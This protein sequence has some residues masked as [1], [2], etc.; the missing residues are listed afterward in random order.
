[1]RDQAFGPVQL[2]E[3]FWIRTDVRQALT[4][5][6]IGALIRLLTQHGIGQTR[7]ATATGLSQARVSELARDH[8]KVKALETFTRIADGL[9]MPDH[10][11]IAL[12]VAPHQPAPV[13]D[14]A[15]GHDD[16]ETEL[17]RQIASARN[18][19]TTVVAAL[20]QETDTIRLL[21]RRLGAP[22][23]T[24]K[25]SAHIDL[26][27]NSLRHSLRPG[28]REPLAAVLA[29]AEA[30]AGWQCIDMGRLHTAWGHFENAIAAARGATGTS[31]LAFSSGEQAY[32]LLDLGHPAEALDMVRAAWDDT[33]RHIPGQL[34]GWLR[35]AEA[36][37]AAVLRREDDCRRAL[38]LAAAEITDGPPDAELPYLALN[39][40]HLARWRGN[41]LIHFG[42]PGT[43]TELSAALAQMNGFTRAE[44]GLRVDLAA[45][46]HATGER[47]EARGH[48]ARA[49]ELARITGSARQCSRITRL[50]KRLGH[51]A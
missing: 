25:L 40:A 21:D 13:R 11:R 18:I 48:L 46:L 31:L 22:A 49:A 7:T 44:A 33:H 32:V 50:A 3:G 43:V 42:D 29:D 37:M 26:I 35:A 41:C 19:D 27:H 8:R 30:L 45:A 23:V 6:D 10:A 2:P 5:R 20:Q 9:A 47:D 34:R 15:T 1:L 16:Q 4:R 17:L 12:G 38:D 39:S 24:G 51:A 14:P 36:E 28:I